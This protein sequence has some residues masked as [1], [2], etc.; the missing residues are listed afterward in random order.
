[1]QRILLTGAF[2]LACC[3]ASFAQN[4]Q[5]AL[6][7]SR[8]GFGGTA[9]Y[10]SMAG[11][12]GAVGPDLSVLSTNPAGLGWYTKNEM[13]FTPSFYNNNI[14]STYNDSISSDSRFNLRFDNVGFVFA[15]KTENSEEEGWQAVGMGFSYNRYSTFQANYNMAGR[16][17]TSLLDSWRET[18]EGT[19]PANL[20]I[21]NEGLGYQVYLLENTNGDST[22][23]RDTIPDG[24]LLRQNKTVR[25]RGGMG[26]WVFGIGGNYSNKFYIG[27]SI[28]L[29]QVKYEE[30]ATYTEREVAD[31]TSDFD[32]LEFNQSLFVKGRGFNFKFGIIYRPIDQVRIGFAFHSPTYLKLADTYGANMGSVIGGVS[33]TYEAPT[34]NFNYTIR[35]PLRMI[36]SLAVI[37]GKTGMISADYELV[38]YSEA[39]LRS[40]S[41]QFTDANNA[42][43]TKYKAASNI[44][45]G[46]EVRLLP[47]IFRAG[48]A[49]YGSPYA[50]G[51]DNSATRLYI[52]GGVGYRD[53]GDKFF[54][55]LGVVTTS[56][57][58]N[59]Y[60][61][62]QSLV[63][64]VQNVS[65]VVNVVV[66]CGF[67]Y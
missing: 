44:R 8:I 21:F 50:D 58:S 54:V 18:A 61:Y 48:F 30:L 65:R 28:G 55:D 47:I 29:P 27:G 67:R 32:Y 23:Y 51:V 38:D 45:V 1:M 16:S 25:T 24:D 37:F 5:D 4:E 26:E 12:F 35:T 40:S 42:I 56:E 10:S 36:G 3:T 9:R 7:Y 6:R 14:T 19:G 43:Q 64:P 59:Y 13:A 17:T 46:G 39:S 41:Y 34:G 62:D 11:A 22:Q 63:N 60:F 31:T 66:T 52:T 53:P 15:G 33:R 2:L 20:D 57:K 49:L